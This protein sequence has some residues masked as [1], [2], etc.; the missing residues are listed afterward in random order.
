MYIDID[1]WF[2]ATPSGYS[3]LCCQESL[4]VNYRGYWGSNP[5]EQHVVIMH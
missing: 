4:L 3:W 5:G 2:G 1:I